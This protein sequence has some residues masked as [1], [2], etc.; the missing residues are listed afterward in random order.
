MRSPFPAGLVPVL[1]ISALLA[2]CDRAE[3]PG[4]DAGQPQFSVSATTQVHFV[5][6]GDFGNAGW[7][8]V[9][10]AGGFRFASISVNRGGPTTDPQTFLNYSVFQC[11]PSFSCNTIR[12]GSGLIPNRDLRSGGN[13]LSLSTNT[14]GNPNFVVSVGPTGVVSA[15]WRANGLFTQSSTAINQITFPSFTEHSQGSFSSA[16]A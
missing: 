11:D 2:A 4:P 13:S 7:F 16:S 9:D 14:T 3:I 8:E 1:T 10:P 15:D 5:A 6:N 12:E